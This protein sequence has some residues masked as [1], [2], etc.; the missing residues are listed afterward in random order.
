[1]AQQGPSRPLRPIA[2]R[3]F[4]DPPTPGPPPE[5]GKI[6]R[7]SMAC[8]ECKRRRTKCNAA[9]TAGS[10]CSE[11]ALHGRECI[12]DEFADKR[13]KISAKRTE[14]SLKFYRG[15][16]EELLEAIRSGDGPSIESIVNIIRSGASHKEIH[17]VI[18]QILSQKPR[19]DGDLL[20]FRKNATPDGK[21]PDMTPDGWP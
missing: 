15:F 7:A 9:E 1:M 8:T 5:E 13:R 19:E 17:S 3:S 4:P 2:P 18:T 20:D 11:C 16:V 21:M 6:K 14:E 12:V 10:P